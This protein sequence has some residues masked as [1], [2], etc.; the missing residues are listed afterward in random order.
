MKESVFYLM[1]LALS[2]TILGLCA[3]SDNEE[4]EKYFYPITIV[5]NPSY[6]IDSKAQLI[7]V[8]IQSNQN[9]WFL[10]YFDGYNKTEDGYSI[11]INWVSLVSTR[12]DV[13]PKTLVLQVDANVG[14]ERKAYIDI[15]SG[16]EPWSE[17]AVLSGSIEI[18][19]DGAE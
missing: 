12:A 4:P 19:Q 3:C 2:V 15:W 6:H 7:E 11:E 13:V 10:N 8:G 5:N 17:K 14:E 9:E 18:L 1:L 16:G